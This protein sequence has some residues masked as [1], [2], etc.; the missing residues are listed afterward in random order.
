M[1]SML[2]L[3]SKWETAIS[4]MCI[5][6]L[7]AG[8]GPTDFIWRVISQLSVL[9]DI[10]AARFVLASGSVSAVVPHLMR[11]LSLLWNWRSDW[12]ILVVHVSVW[13][14]MVWNV[15]HWLLKS[16]A[17][18]VSSALSAA[19]ASTECT[20][21]ASSPGIWSYSSFEHVGKA[22]LSIGGTALPIKCF[23]SA[24]HNVF[25]QNMFWAGRQVVSFR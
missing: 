4:L 3:S 11:V 16:L 24:T 23:P 25:S 7:L 18:G 12:F 10:G 15:A 8:R 9:A 21:S 14:S 22:V 6:H 5:S 13:A 2:R 1:S 19:T 20:N 17:R